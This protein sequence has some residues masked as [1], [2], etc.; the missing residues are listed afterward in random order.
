MNV[1]KKHPDI[2]EIKRQHN[3]GAIGFRWKIK[4]KPE[5]LLNVIRDSIGLSSENRKILK[6]IINGKDFRSLII[7]EMGFT[8]PYQIF[9]C[10]SIIAGITTSSKKLNKHI[11]NKFSFKRHKLPIV[12]PEIEKLAVS[13]YSKINP[14]KPNQGIIVKKI[15]KIKEIGL[16]IAKLP[17][18]YLFEL[19]QLTPTSMYTTQF[20]E[21]TFSVFEAMEEIYK[22][23]YQ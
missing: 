20:I 1:I 3:P 10:I 5:P 22:K 9:E 16:D 6:K 15:D 11:S 13:K 2:F 7:W 4:S 14:L 18:S 21:S 19:S 12:I 17:E 8:S 23:H